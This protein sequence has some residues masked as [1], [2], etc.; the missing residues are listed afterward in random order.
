MSVIQISLT[1]I[2]NLEVHEFIKE[3]FNQDNVIFSPL[4]SQYR[5]DIVIADYDLFSKSDVSNLLDKCVLLNTY[6]SNYFVPKGDIITYSIYFTIKHFEKGKDMFDHID[7]WWDS[8]KKGRIGVDVKGPRRDKRKGD[9]NDSI[10]WVELKNVQGNDGWLYGKAKYIAFRTLSSIIYVDRE[11]LL[12]YTI[13]KVGD[14]ETVYKCPNDFYIPYQRYCRLDKVVKVPM[15]DL[16]KI[17]SFS[18]EI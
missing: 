9:F 11:K 2:T 1:N 14:K 8:P 13:E 15:D 7:F 18:I 4:S 3:L 12:A 6:L 16:K 5:N 17:A 10:Q